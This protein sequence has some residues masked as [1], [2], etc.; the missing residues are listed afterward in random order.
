MARPAAHSR[1]RAG[2]RLLDL[3]TPPTQSTVASKLLQK[4]GARQGSNKVMRKRQPT[5]LHLS[6]LVLGAQSLLRKTKRRC[7]LLPTKTGYF[8][9]PRNGKSAQKPVVLR[10]LPS[11]S[12]NS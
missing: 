10:G 12:I 9:G 6:A 8:R 11:S 1:T 2:K 7:Q 5:C 4:D 3:G